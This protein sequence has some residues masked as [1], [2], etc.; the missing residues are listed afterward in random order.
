M[1]IHDYYTRL[2]IDPVKQNIID[3]AI[4]DFMREIEKHGLNAPGDDRV[5]VVVEAMAKY[6]YEANVS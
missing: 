6:L 1:S 4:D 5:E 2:N 3:I